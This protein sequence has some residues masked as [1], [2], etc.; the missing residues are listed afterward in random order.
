MLMFPD[1]HYTSSDMS[2]SKSKMSDMVKVIAPGN[3][4]N[5]FDNLRPNSKQSSTG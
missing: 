2:E 4:R 3:Q 5:Y 1:V